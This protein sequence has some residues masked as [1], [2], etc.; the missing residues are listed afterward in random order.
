M[1]PSVTII[2]HTTASSPR[3]HILYSVQVNLGG[4]RH[5]VDKRYSEFI[6][7]HESLQDPFQLPPKRFLVTAF[8]PSA[9][10]DDA[11]IAERKVGLENYLRDLIASDEFKDHPT[12]NEFL[13]IDL[14]SVPR[15]FSLE[16]VLPST[17][18]RKAG[19]QFTS[20][21]ELS[22]TEDPQVGTM[23][24]P[25]AAAYYP[26]WSA[27]AHPP[28]GI[29][30]SKFDILFFAFAMPNSASSL[31]WDSGAQDILRRLVSSARNSGKGTK[32]VLSVGGWGG[33][34]W[35]S[36]A[37]IS[38]ANRTTFKNALVSA[39]NSFGLD[40]VDIDW[41]YPNS[42]GAG[43]PHS[44]ADA[45]NLLS[46]FQTLR[47]AL[48]S[49]KIISAA[50][51]HLPWLGSNGRP[52][53]SVSSYAAQLTYVNIM[54][55]D[56]WGASSNPGPNAPLG[57][58][59]GTSTQP[60]ASAQAALSQWKNAGFPA[61]KLLLGLPLYGY[62]SQSTRTNLTGSLLPSEDMLL[63]HQNDEP[64]D[65][66]KRHFL[67][68]AHARPQE[69]KVVA[70]ANGDLSGWFGQQIPFNSI[71]ASGA[72]V[73]KSDGTYGQGAGYTMAWD[74]CSDTPF[75]F[76]VSR[77]TVV[78]YDDTWSLADKALFAKQNG[79]AGC[80]TWSLD[81][82]DGVSLQNII[83]KNLGK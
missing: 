12:L 13:T 66:P 61:S 59:C 23:A 76:N 80:F 26:D 55:Y 19:A 10:A 69:T 73:K 7:L 82:D 63:L 44:S 30:Y 77:R 15:H 37:V 83:R 67:N 74:N 49:S 56:V 54:N 75:L 81:Q 48:G 42:T 18:S 53:T 11:L 51:P 14:T 57:N 70:E 28:E 38:S 46:F 22:Q 47:G 78:T 52:L 71:L 60:Q 25:I 6:T 2:S 1:P 62:V 24:T 4:K 79:M 50:V 43:N 5:V 35:F 20:L 40:G 64:A 31:T 65:S 45:A 16:D 8:V 3:P 72:L 27:G 41:E 29:D 36:Q 34:T 9:W 32:I 21:P 58:L 68:G 39:V 17:L 33:S